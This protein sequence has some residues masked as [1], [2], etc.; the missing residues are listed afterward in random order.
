MEDS[1]EKSWLARNVGY[2][3]DVS[4]ALTFYIML[5]MIFFLKVPEE[6]KEIFYTAFGILGAKYGSSFDFHRGSSSG[7][8]ASGDIL[9]K[10][11]NKQTSDGTI[12]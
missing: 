12:N 4:V 6:N 2:M 10:I 8:K 7:S 1:K 11:M 3:L 9:R 5:F